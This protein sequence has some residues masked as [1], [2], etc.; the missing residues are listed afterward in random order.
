MISP[1]LIQLFYSYKMGMVTSSYD[2]AA[3]ILV[4]LISY[5]GGSRKRPVF[6]AWGVFTVGIGSLIFMLPHFVSSPYKA[7]T[8]M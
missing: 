5:I 4:P 1:E 7:G 3:M 6:C 2:I 8:Y